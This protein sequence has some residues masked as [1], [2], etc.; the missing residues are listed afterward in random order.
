MAHLV[1]GLTEGEMDNKNSVQNMVNLGRI[2]GYRIF[3]VACDLFNHGRFRYL[4]L[5]CPASS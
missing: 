3:A 1:D 5:A 4:S 2:F